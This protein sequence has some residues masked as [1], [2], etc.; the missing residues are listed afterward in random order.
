MAQLCSTKMIQQRQLLSRQIKARLSD[1]VDKYIYLSKHYNGE[2]RLHYSYLSLFRNGSAIWPESKFQQ[3]S[4]FLTL[5][6]SERS[7]HSRLN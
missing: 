6:E 4:K 7:I 2:K 1:T 5:A 3:I